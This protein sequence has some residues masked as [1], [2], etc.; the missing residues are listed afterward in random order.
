MESDKASALSSDARVAGKVFHREPQRGGK[1]FQVQLAIA[2]GERGP[3]NR[4]L[5]V[6]LQQVLVIDEGLRVLLAD[7]RCEQLLRQDNAGALP[8]VTAVTAETDLLEAIAGRDDP[9]I[10]HGPAEAATEIFEDGGIAGGL[11]DEVVEGLVAAGDDAGGRDVVSE[12]AAVHYLGKER[13]LRDELAEQVRDVL[14]AFEREGLL[15][16]GASAE[17][18]KY[19]AR[20]GLHGSGE[21]RTH[22]RGDGRGRDRAADQAQ[23]F[24][25]RLAA[26]HRGERVGRRRHRVGILGRVES[27]RVWLRL[28]TSRPSIYKR[29]LIAPSGRLFPPVLAHRSARDRCR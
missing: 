13:P 17:G 26:Q 3:V 6:V 28:Y 19:G 21:G 29:R 9:G 16:A 14:L 12:D 18:D 27:M 23:E 7:R 20:P 5:V 4:H 8:F 24:A 11:C 22:Q 25:A 2:L 10:I 15:I 1:L